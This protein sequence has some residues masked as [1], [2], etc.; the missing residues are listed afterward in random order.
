MLKLPTYS[1]AAISRPSL[2]L[3][4]LRAIGPGVVIVKAGPTGSRNDSTGCELLR[5]YLW[6]WAFLPQP[7]AHFPLNETTNTKYIH[8]ALND[9]KQYKTFG[10]G[11]KNPEIINKYRL[12]KTTSIPMIMRWKETSELFNSKPNDWH[13]WLLN[14]TTFPEAGPVVIIGSPEGYLSYDN[15]ERTEKSTPLRQILTE[16]GYGDNFKLLLPHNGGG[17]QLGK[18]KKITI[19]ERNGYQRDIS[20]I[21]MGRASNGRTVVVLA[22][23]SNTFGTFSAIRVAADYGRNEVNS[24]VLDFI[25]KPEMANAKI[26]FFT[27]RHIYSGTFKPLRLTD[28]ISVRF[29]EDFDQHPSKCDLDFRKAESELN[30]LDSTPTIPKTQQTTLAKFLSEQG[31]IGIITKWY[32]QD[33][34]D[35]AT[36]MDILEFA[37]D[38]SVNYPVPPGIPIY[39]KGDENKF[40]D[41]INA[42]VSSKRGRNQDKS[43]NNKRNLE[44]SL[45][46]LD[47]ECYQLF[48]LWQEAYGKL[49]TTDDVFANWF[50]S[51]F[52]TPSDGPVVIMGTPSSFLGSGSQENERKTNLCKMLTRAGFPNRYILQNT[53]IHGIIRGEIF[54]RKT[55][56]TKYKSN[57]SDADD[58]TH[59]EDAGIISLSK[60]PDGRDVL[61]V[62]GITWLG[63]LAGV[64]LL[65]TQQRPTIDRCIQDYSLG[66]RSRIDIFYTCKVPKKISFLGDRTADTK[67]TIWPTHQDLDEIAIDTHESETEPEFIHNKIAEECFHDLFIKIK[68]LKSG[69]VETPLAEKENFSFEL[70]TRNPKLL[71]LNVSC[72]HS[73][74]VGD[75][76][77][78]CGSELKALYQSID[79][80]LEED[81]SHLSDLFQE[82]YGGDEVKRLQI[83]FMRSAIKAYCGKF[84]ILGESGVGKENIAKYLNDSIRKKLRYNSKLVVLN[85]ACIPEPLMHG[86]IFGSVKGA[87]TSGEGRIS[88]FEEAIGGVFFLDEFA[89]LDGSPSLTL[90]ASLLRAMENFTFTR[91]GSPTS[92]NINCLLVAATNRATSLKELQYLMGSKVI[93]SDVGNRFEG[94][95][96]SFPPLRERPLEI[97]P[98]FISKIYDNYKKA[99]KSPP[100][101]LLT[102]KALELLLHFNFPGNFRQLDGIAKGLVR[103]IDFRKEKQELQISLQHMHQC[104]FLGSSN[105]VDE[106]DPD[107]VE[108]S[109]SFPN[110]RSC[111]LWQGINEPGR[112]LTRPVFEFREFLSVQPL[113]DPAYR[114]VVKQRGKSND[115]ESYFKRYFFD[116]LNISQQSH[117]VINAFDG[118]I[119]AA[120]A[121][122]SKISSLPKI[123]GRGRTKDYGAMQ[124]FS[125]CVWLMSKAPQSAYVELT[126]KINSSSDSSDERFQ[127]AHQMLAIF[128]HDDELQRCIDWEFFVTIVF[129]CTGFDIRTDTEKKWMNWV[130]DRRGLVRLA[131]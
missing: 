45:M 103:L 16:A 105:C 127:I 97:L 130:A 41:I 119:S 62:A 26:A 20:L 63:T 10:G 18:G 7:D 125:A 102:V 52:Q 31:S 121:W 77:I 1:A 33:L 32:P 129:L 91:I 75:L 108:I 57:T 15:P 54:D 90:Q 124:Q 24:M 29:L 59:E 104:L 6:Q 11:E 98:A 116:L 50:D 83:N 81:Y 70:K 36:A 60:G 114:F 42:F 43:G 40:R 100:C 22:G 94:R 61:I 113:L 21:F 110:A 66:L 23:S 56:T 84:F 37:L 86:E 99:K 72:Q 2:L 48:S 27:E 115:Q 17:M 122:F 13:D 82:H 93:R 92:L 47:D 3:Q 117:F 78:A 51:Q 69:I 128:V 96:F 8:D 64:R 39:N 89:A 106:P 34:R 76:N 44:K 74:T 12:W 79:N 109:V 111:N 53:G 4:F 107:F 123:N 101:V 131:F 87:Y 49:K 30:Q 55:F 71:E 25:K 46:Y 120:K 38:D 118:L 112:K 88:P 58:F 85:T 80:C 126:K 19:E 14:K 67:Q 5:Y 65:F 9:V 35:D 73:I 28:S 68:D 95:L